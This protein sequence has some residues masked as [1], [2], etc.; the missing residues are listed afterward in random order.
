MTLDSLISPTH[1]VPERKVA[2]TASGSHYPNHIEIHGGVRNA[3][4]DILGE[5]DDGKWWMLVEPFSQPS[6]CVVV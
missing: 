4:V 2:L 1:G 3:Y 5:L 6:V